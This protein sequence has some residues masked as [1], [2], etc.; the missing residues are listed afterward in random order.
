MPVFHIH[1]QNFIVNAF[2]YWLYNYS[3]GSRPIF[4][5]QVDQLIHRILVEEDAKNSGESN[6]ELF[7]ASA[8]VGEKLYK[9]GDFAK[10]QISKLDIYLLRKV[11]KRFLLCLA[12]HS[13]FVSFLFKFFLKNEAVTNGSFSG[14]F[15]SR[16]LGAQSEVAF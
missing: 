14:W 5:P 13:S 6:D 4:H 11:R 12:S 2:L 16:C 7:R 8:D 9:K 1:G 15:I 10:S 3:Q